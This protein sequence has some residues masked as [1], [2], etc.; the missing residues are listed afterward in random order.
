MSAP[1]IFVVANFVREVSLIILYLLLCMK[2]LPK[3]SH[4]EQKTMP[5]DVSRDGHGILLVETLFIK[6]S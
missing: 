4:C 2:S 5:V 1:L 6:T 3:P